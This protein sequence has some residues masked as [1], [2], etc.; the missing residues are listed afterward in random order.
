MQFKS[1]TPSR[2]DAV[3][4]LE[5]DNRGDTGAMYLKLRWKGLMEGPSSGDGTGHKTWQQTVMDIPIAKWF[6][7]EVYLRQSSAYTGRITVWQDGVQLYDLDQ[8]NTKY[9]DGDN[10]WSINAYG[11][12]T[13]PMPFT[14]YVD[15]AAVS[16]DRIWSALPGDLTGDGQVTLADLRLLVSMLLGQTAPSAEAESLAAPADQLTLSDGLALIE[17]LAG[18]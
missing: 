5:L 4:V 17:I 3:W 16:T 14:I 9:P 11:D 7:V 10:R 13:T 6:H 12:D 18:Q 15:D 8:V 1:K 2:N